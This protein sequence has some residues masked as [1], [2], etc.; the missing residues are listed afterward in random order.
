MKK[1]VKEKVNL[2]ILKAIWLLFSLFFQVKEKRKKKGALINFLH[3]V[4]EG[5]G[6]IAPLHLSLVLSFYF[7]FLL[8][9]V[10]FCFS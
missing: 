3:Q 4:N 6:I 5:K 7:S 10:I 1:K 8:C 9:L 2:N